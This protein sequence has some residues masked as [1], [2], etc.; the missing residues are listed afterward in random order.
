[1]RRSVRILLWSLVSVVVLVLIASLALLT[2][3]PPLERRL[4]A[5]VIEALRQHY[6]RDVQLQN[7]KVTLVPQFEATADNFILPN[8][9]IALPSFITARHFTVKAGVLELLRRPVHL[10]SVTFDGLEIHVPPKGS[11]PKGNPGTPPQPKRRAHLANFVIDRVY[12]DGTELYVLRK[13]PSAEPM[14]F[15]IRKLALRSAGIGQPMKFKAELTN[16]KP[17]GLIESSG[18]FGPW[19]LD[20]P[21]ATNVSGHYTF[22]KA[23]LSIF[24]GISGILS[25]IGDYKGQLSDI[26]VDGTTDT[27][28]FRLDRGATPV[29]LTTTF[30]AVVDGTNGN[31]Y[32]QP[33]NAHFLKSNVVARGQV[34]GKP[35]QKGKTISLDVEV[36]D[37]R[38]EDL[39]QLASKQEDPAVTG[40]IDFDGHV[41]IPPGK[42]EVLKKLALDG[43]FQVEQARF[44]SDKVQNAVGELSRRGLGKSKE[45][46]TQDVPA[47]FAGDFRFQNAL[48]R[49][50]RFQFSV[51]G[52]MARFTGSYGLR[53]EQVD[54]VGEVK[55]NA[56]VSQVVGGKKKWLLVPFDPLF[57]KH[58]AGTYLPVHI[59]GA[60]N[61]PEIKLDWKKLF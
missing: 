10:S 60:R 15:Q 7:L 27:P 53:S 51:P 57:S 11:S 33:V 16:P 2:V 34:A 37:S 6:Q 17:P 42:E 39:L 21:S 30:H 54:F 23:D 47:Q 58:S 31:T 4:Q 18:S 46:S 5:K 9:D 28:D 24:N 25:S 26:I 52:A 40:K 59:E 22:E 44:T 12:A 32:L 3:P 35:G 8:K 56:K 1:M 41:L 61:H 45:Q 50:D 14:E 55:L 43:R 19:N 49:F 29:H 48:L 20:E 13:D 36:N 38:L